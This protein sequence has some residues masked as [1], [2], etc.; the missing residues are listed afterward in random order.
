MENAFQNVNVLIKKRKIDLKIIF[1]YAIVTLYH[2]LSTMA[3]SI[4]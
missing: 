3:T 2:L 1:P 4:V